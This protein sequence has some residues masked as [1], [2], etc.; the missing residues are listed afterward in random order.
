MSEVG[1]HGPPGPIDVANVFGLARTNI[2]FIV[3]CFLA[4][5]VLH[6]RPLINYVK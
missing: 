6:M 4:V 3:V 1:C 2:L 5:K